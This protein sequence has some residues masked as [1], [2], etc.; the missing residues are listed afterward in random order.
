LVIFLI[1]I[2]GLSAISYLT[3]YSIVLP[4]AGNKKA[5]LNR[6]VKVGDE[7]AVFSRF[8]FSKDNWKAYINLSTDDFSDLHPAIKKRSC[9][10]TISRRL[11]EQMQKSWRFK[12]TDGD[13]GS[14]SSDF[15]LFKNGKLVYKTG[16]ILSKTSQRFQN[17]E[18]GEM[19]PV[20]SVAM[21]NVCRQF[22]SVYWPIVIL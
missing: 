21:I 10:K 5:Y 3:G 6:K 8:D 20:D 18:Y 16:I 19:V 4:A 15:Y 22:K 17:E 13:A 1:V 14:V 12:I 2:I 9:L 7:L 11:L